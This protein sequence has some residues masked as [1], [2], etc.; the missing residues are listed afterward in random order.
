MSQAATGIRFFNTLTRQKE[1]FMP[2]DEGR[3]RM[4]TCG[5]T[6]YDYAHIGN[7]R[8]FVF[9]DVLKRWLKYRGLQVTHVMNLTDVDDKTIRGSQKQQMSLRQFTDFYAKAFFEDVAVLNIE[10]ADYY[11]RATEHI[12]EMVSLIKRLMDKGFAYRGEDGSIYYAVIKFKDYGKLSKIKVAE[13]KAGARVKVDEY[14]KEEAQDFALWKAWTQEDGDVCWDTE[15]GKGRPGWH[16]ECSAMSMRY[17]GETFDIHCGGVDNMFPHHENEIAQSEAATGKRFVNYW[18]HNEHLLVEGKRMAK[19]YGNFYTLRDLLSKG[20]DPIAIR[21]LLLS[22]HYRQQFNFTF[23][24]LEAAKGAVERLR[25]FIHRLQDADGKS[26]GEKMAKLTAKVQMSF[27]E[28]MDDDLNISVALA[29]LFDFVRDVNNLLDANA[30]SRAEAKQACALIADF[31]RVLGVIGKI[32]ADAALPKEAEE[33]IKKREEARK[34]KDWKTADAIR[35][36][37]KAMGVVIEDTTQ[38]VRWK[39]EKT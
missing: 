11:P 6:V 35:Q 21:Y 17:L 32:E 25:N 1:A 39:I 37:L 28:A 4:Y 22:T 26:S 34:N 16:I 33:L 27:G 13:L 7:F 30:V 31:D 20:Y 15:L 36:Q 5:P 38:G 10:R 18:L 14:S 12:A 19:R 9:E 8:A 2:I 3:V 24:G 23:E 29:A